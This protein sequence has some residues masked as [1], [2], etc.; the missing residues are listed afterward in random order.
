MPIIF[1]TYYHLRKVI[2]FLGEGLLIFLSLL[3]VDWFMLS[4]GLFYLDLPLNSARALLVTLIFLFC[5]YLFDLYNVNGDL[6]LPHTFT[7]MIQ[8]FGIGCIILAAIYYF[9]P[10]MIITM[11]MFWTGYIAICLTVSL[12]RAAYYFILRNR[13][14]VQN[15]LV[16]GT[17]SLAADIAVEVEGVQDSVHRICGFVGTGQPTFNPYNA[18]VR[19]CLEEFEELLLKHKLQRIVVALDDLR[20]GTPIKTLLKCKMRGIFIEQG[21]TFYERLTGKILVEKVPPSWIIYSD[22]FRSSRLT[23]GLKRMLDVTAAITLLSFSMPVML[24]TA[25]L[26]KLES[27]G[28]VL[29]FQERVGEKNRPFLL[30]KFRSMRQDAEK[31]GAV[32]AMENDPRVTRVGAV[33][34]HLRIDELP[35]LFNILKGEMSLVGPRPERQVFIDQLVKKIPFYEIR[36]ELKPGVTGWAQVCYPYGASERDALKKLEYD[37]YYMKN[38]SLAF[39]LLIIFKTVKTI[40]SRKGAR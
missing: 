2:F 9:F 18:P 7:R 5:L 21:V 13:Y 20:G 28:P 38:L 25:L 26:I 11:I 19:P 16:V 30:I 17:G 36:H 40:L 35:Q 6:T 39:D 12:W 3:A 31:D 37:L 22:G 15:I 27:P 33:I 24:L 32:W 1:N 34:R 4:P 14:F 29:Y 8:A 23:Y 10:F